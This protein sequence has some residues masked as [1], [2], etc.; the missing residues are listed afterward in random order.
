MLGNQVSRL[1]M[2]TFTNIT[3]MSMSIQERRRRIVAEG[4][5]TQE[6]ANKMAARLIAYIDDGDC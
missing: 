5:V 3:A 1:Y 6:A 2:R 4:L